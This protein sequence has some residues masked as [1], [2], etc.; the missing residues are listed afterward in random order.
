VTDGS[1]EGRAVALLDRFEAALNV[2]MLPNFWP[3]MSGGGLEQAGA[4]V[5]VNELLLQSHEGFLSFFPAW[6]TDGAAG[7][8]SFISLRAR[9]AFLVSARVS[10]G[11]TDVTIYSEVGATCRLLSLWKGVRP[12][13]RT[14][15]G[16]TVEVAAVSVKGVA[17]WEFKTTKGTYTLDAK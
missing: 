7:D 12:V 13:V 3:S 2:T 16:T 14:W 5:A 8:V 1:R 17:V 11:V 9:G 6:G 15:S 10:T 4:A